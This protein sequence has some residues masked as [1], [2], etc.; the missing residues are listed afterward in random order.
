MTSGGP[1]WLGLLQWSLAHQD[2][3]APSNAEMM[4]RENQEWLERVLKEGVIDEPK[5]IAEHI[6]TVKLHLDA[7]EISPEDVELLEDVAD[8]TDQIDMA[9]VFVKLGGL[10]LVY[11]IISEYGGSTGVGERLLKAALGLIGSVCQNH[12]EVQAHAV[13]ISPGYSQSLLGA[14]CALIRSDHAM[15]AAV[16]AKALLAVSCMVRGNIDGERI[17]IFDHFNA[18][19]SH[20]TSH[21]CTLA[22][23]GSHNVIAK[24]MFL[25]R[26]LLESEHTSRQR[27]EIVAS[28]M[29][30]ICHAAINSCDVN[31]RDCGVGLVE[32]I[33]SSTI[34]RTMVATHLANIVSSADAAIERLNMQIMQCTSDDEVVYLREDLAMVT[35]FKAT[36]TSDSTALK[37][38]PMEPENV[39][40]M[41]GAP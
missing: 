6:Q 21:H 23:E 7:G 3:T 27:V 25:S 36:I 30:P 10:K 18:M 39:L 26:A 2:G 19:F 28:V 20:L 8:I 14:V 17:L 9:G 1:N 34:G 29:L 22:D 40:M 16:Y 31:V 33:V 15:P 35:A 24:M 5:R 12:P 37:E 11:S 41:I 4:T 32:I 38:I 13:R